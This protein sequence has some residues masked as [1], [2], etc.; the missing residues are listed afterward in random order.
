MHNSPLVFTAVNHKHISVNQVFKYSVPFYRMTSVLIRSGFKMY[1]IKSLM[2][3][4]SC[5]NDC[6][7]VFFFFK[8][9]YVF[10]FYMRPVYLK[11]IL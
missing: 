10:A 4:C 11:V 2:N 7:I 9:Q 1:P 6:S 3:I 8:C 5:V